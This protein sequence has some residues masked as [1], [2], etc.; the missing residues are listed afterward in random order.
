LVRALRAHGLNHG[1]ITEKRDLEMPGISVVFSCND[2]SQNKVNAS[3]QEMKHRDHYKT[4]KYLKNDKL[5]IG[6]SSYKGYPLHRY[7]DNNVLF[8][9]EGLI[10]N[11][12]NQEIDDS[13]RRIADEYSQKKNYKKPM[14][15]LLENSDGDYIGLIYSKTDNSILIFN[16]RWGRLPAF[17]FSEDQIFAF[18]RE[19]KFLLHWISNINFDRITMAEF[20]IFHYNLGEK[21]LIKGIKR[22]DP[23]TILEIK[24]PNCK[25]HVMK[26]VLQS[27]N[28]EN[29]DLM[30]TRDQIIDQ[31]LKLFK[32]SLATRVRKVRK[33]GLHIVADLSGGYDSRAI[34]GALCQMG[35]D[36]TPCTDKLITG[37]ESDIA[38]QLAESYNKKLCV[39][40]SIHPVDD[41]KILRNITYLTDCAVNGYIAVSNYYD[42]LEREKLFREPTAHFMGLAGEFMRW[43]IPSKKRYPTIY[44]F[45][46]AAHYSDYLPP[47]WALAITNLNPHEFRENLEREIARFPEKQPEE[48]IKHLRFEYLNKVANGGEDRHRM[49]SWTVQPFLAK[50]LLTF[51]KKNIPRK[52]LSTKFFIDFLS[53][54]DHRLL[55]LPFHGINMR[56]DSRLQTTLYRI[57][58]YLKTRARAN[59]YISGLYKWVNRKF[60]RNLNKSNIADEI[61][62]LCKNDFVSKQFNIA[63]VEEFLIQSY[64]MRE[65]YQLLTLMIYVD[66]VGRRFDEKIKR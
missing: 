19:K 33:K 52:M 32:E 45:M 14:A 49:F 28:F 25:I 17:F 27:V 15:E 55:E 62:K 2:L 48:K 47:S 18:S 41:F 37:D 42:S 58:L 50:D 39:S 61:R 3:F 29:E 11:K 8:L 1:S 10:Y 59:H 7:E 22:F 60:S 26:D 54:L 9:L 4:G 6:F 31:C 5:V 38:R 57:K 23:A 21:T 24:P 30:L 53:R 36:F 56:L 43:S 63:A 46:D 40:S 12:T 20:L 16:D 65:V 13:A 66:E 64:T 51:E 35:V 44:E 34:F